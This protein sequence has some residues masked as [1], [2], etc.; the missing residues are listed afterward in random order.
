MVDPGGTL[1]MSFGVAAAVLMLVAAGYA[2]RRRMMKQASRFGL[3]K[4]RTWLSVHL[5]TGGAFL[6]CVLI[7][8]GFSLPNGG[9]G[10][11]LLGLSLWV[12][13][14]GIFG[15][16]LQQSIPK[17]LGAGLTN[18]VHYDRIPELIEEIKK[19]SEAYAIQCGEPVLSLF[20]RDIRPV[21]EEP[22]RDARYFFDITGRIS[23]RL[24]TLDYLRRMLGSEQS[25]SLSEIERLLKAKLEIDAHY[26][27]QFA[28]RA[29]LALHVPPS[30]LLVCA[31]GLHVFTIAYW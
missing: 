14:T 16:L 26:T 17:A 5:W 29:W 6:A 19:E 2:V 1:G 11:L 28:L 4:A 20:E 30:L 7:H 8:M 27:L 15:L 13:G 22:T 9:M 10:W 31:V 25:E 21:L 12:V 23:S 18:E 3:G 24:G